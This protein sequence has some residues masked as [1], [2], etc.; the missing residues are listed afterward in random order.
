MEQIA[1]W[2]GPTLGVVAAIASGVFAAMARR[3]EARGRERERQR[4][5]LKQ[6]IEPLLYAASDLQSRIYNILQLRFLE[7]YQNS[8]VDRWRENSLE[9]TCFLFAQYFGWAEATRQ[10]ALFRES[11]DLVAR[12]GT[13]R[14]RT[15]VSIAAVIREVNDALRTD[16]FGTDVM[17]FSGEQHAIG[18]LMFS[19]DVVGDARFPS[20][21]R[22]ATF[23]ERFQNEE[24]FRRWFQG[25]I[26]PLENGVT[27]V[28]RRRLAMVQNHLVDLMD[29]LDPEH[30][31]YKRR[32]KVPVAEL[33]PLP[34]RR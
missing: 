14:D 7:A 5:V 24:H 13:S 25:I 15:A 20:V 26:D 34:E 18:E 4:D 29:L 12:D 30:N 21:M 16:S 11:K 3:A 31:V 10:A 33:R 23:A 1:V 22:Y 27:D 19:W 6:S 32:S 28:G 17:L 8:R 2:L 9:Y